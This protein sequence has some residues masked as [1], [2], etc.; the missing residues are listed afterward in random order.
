[1]CLLVDLLEPLD[2]GV[3]VD[4]GRRDRWGTEQLLHGAQVRARIEQMGGEGVSERVRGK[5]GAL[6]DLVEKPFHRNLDGPYRDSSSE[7]AQKKSGAIALG[8]D[9]TQQLVSLGLVVS[10][11][12]LSVITDGND[13]FLPPLP[14]HFHLLREE[15][16]VHAVDTAQLGQAPSR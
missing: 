8:A 1:M 11:R 13:A 12:Q 10:E 5:S 2:A 4:L 3:S 6:V 14:P 15:I 9:G 7:T 16:D